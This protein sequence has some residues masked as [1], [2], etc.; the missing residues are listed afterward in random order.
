METQEK[1][2]QTTVIFK[3]TIFGCTDIKVKYKYKFVKSFSIIFYI[4][5]IM[6]FFICDIKSNLYSFFRLL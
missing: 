6:R 2:D 3:S 4:R 5:F 1:K